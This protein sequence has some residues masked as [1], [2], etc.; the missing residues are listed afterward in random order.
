ML[1]EQ[2]MPWVYQKRCHKNSTMADKRMPAIVQ[3]NVVCLQ[4]LAYEISPPWLIASKIVL[5]MLLKFVLPPYSVPPDDWAL[6]A[7]RA[8]M[9][10]IVV[11]LGQPKAAPLE[12]TLIV[13]TPVPKIPTS[14]PYAAATFPAS[15]ELVT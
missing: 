14:K 13:R 8:C 2:E 7:C 9:M 4:N 5:A 11:L 6:A 15:D 10:V 3:R 1:D 12:P